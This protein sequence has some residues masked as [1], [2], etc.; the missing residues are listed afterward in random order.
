MGGA[1]Y[2]A[3]IPHKELQATE[4][5]WEWERQSFP[6]KNTPVCCQMPMVR[7]EDKPTL[8]RLNR[9]HSEIYMYIDI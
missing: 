8:Y 9:L 6:G 5:S 7:P 4:G 3:L 2:D 1:G